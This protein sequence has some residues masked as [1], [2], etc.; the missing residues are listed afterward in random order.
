MMILIAQV[1]FL[2]FI[3]DYPLHFLFFLSVLV[4]VMAARLSLQRVVEL[5]SF[6]LVGQKTWKMNDSIIE[7]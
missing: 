1:S 5:Y 3:S 2:V 6:C 7:T 4:L